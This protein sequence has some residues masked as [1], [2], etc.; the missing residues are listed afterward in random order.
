MYIEFT[1]IFGT[2]TVYCTIERKRMSS[3]AEI[4]LYLH[5]S[6]CSGFSGW[7]MGS[8]SREINRILT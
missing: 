6:A 4:L 8:H 7:I 5:T 3:L 2:F 1:Q